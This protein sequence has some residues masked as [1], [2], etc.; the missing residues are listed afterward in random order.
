[1]KKLLLCLISILVLDA[2]VLGCSSTPTPTAPAPA[3]PKTATVTA[4]ATATATVTAT[5]VPKP[6][7][8]AP[9]PTAAPVT[10]PK[11]TLRAVSYAPA[12]AYTTKLWL[13]IGDAIKTKSNGEVVVDYVGGPEVVG[14][15]DQA[16]AAKSG[17]VDIAWGI[18]GQMV[19]IVP[20][21][22]LMRYS[23]LMPWEE[24]ANGAFD[25]QDKNHQAAGLK[26]LAIG[27]IGSKD[28]IDGIDGSG[29][30]L[31]CLVKKEVKT[32]ADLKGLKIGTEVGGKAWVPKMGF[33]ET[34][35][36]DSELFDALK[37]GMADGYWNPM[38]RIIPSGL[39][40]VTKY[41]LLN[42][43]HTGSSYSSYMIIR[44]WKNLSA[45]QHKAVTDASAEIERVWQPDHLAYI[46][47][48]RDAVK[49]KGI[50]MLK[51]SA[52]EGKTLSTMA[53]QLDS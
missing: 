30:P 20:G 11:V 2:L 50:G 53:R 28:A 42:C 34:F 1:M 45:S 43:C 9:S 5:A 37:K 39:Q 40:D 15:L 31:L 33:E 41:V 24:R 49:A 14:G 48:Q 12:V 18:S 25:I 21:A 13:K 29:G 7:T 17:V 38:A 32:L 19:T 46:G 8:A 16:M 10:T 4:T 51:L 3:P 27:P 22:G 26:L 6:T 44:T 52:D 23:R 35:I 47:Q 36:Q